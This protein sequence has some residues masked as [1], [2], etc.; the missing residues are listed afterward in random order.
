MMPEQAMMT[1][2]L[3][4]EG[5]V[6]SSLVPE[7][8]TAKAERE[9]NKLK[10][11]DR[12]AH[13]WYRFVLSFPPHLV[14]EY[15]AKFGLDSHHTVLDPFCGTGTTLVECQKLG[16]PAFGLE[17]NPVVCFASQ[18]KLQW[19]IHPQKLLGHAMT[20]AES[21]NRRLEQDGF[22]D[23][24]AYRLLE[25]PAGANAELSTL[26]EE[27]A[28]LL[29][30]NS[31]SPIPLHKT[32]VLLQVLADNHDD[33]FANHERLALAA[34]LVSGISN[35]Q[36]GPEVGVGPAKSDAP[37]I[38][39]WLDGIRAMAQ[40]LENLPRAATAKGVVY[41]ADARDGASMLPA[42]SVDAVITSPPYPNEKDYTR[43]TRLESVLLGFI[44]SKE[45]LRTLKKQ[46]VRSNTR[47]VYKADTD[48]LLV[49]G[50]PQIEG[51]AA[52][53][54]KRRIELNKDSGFERLYA[55]VT[56]LYFGGMARHLAQL[57]RVL[58]PGARL[59]YVVGDQASYLR[60]MIRT[61]QLLAGIAE[62]LGYE[63]VS[64]DLFRTRLAT[65]TKEQLREEV[66]VLRW[67]G[68]SDAKSEGYETKEPILRH[69]RTNLH[70]QVQARN[71]DGGFCAG[72]I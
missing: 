24:D 47:G 67:P 39:L 62:S 23:E 58:R 14:R 61:G 64:L 66:V 37:V 56:K 11:D 52:A 63:V 33:H 46:M 59:A 22:F 27:A 49:A 15:V 4:P 16:I 68:A 53:I 50:H 60:V 17:P 29:L 32:L 13:Q 28:D 2:L 42:N 7:R 20:V 45:D 1:G 9:D 57:R 6:R 25:R 51:I 12:A 48:H 69:H 70:L 5:K 8:R 55:R 21:A 35:L 54:E 71:E 10:L 30:T 72:G 43:T 3:F 36:F 44:Q 38:S 34:A 19:N 40:D 41:Q 31:I 65:A 26:P 18:T